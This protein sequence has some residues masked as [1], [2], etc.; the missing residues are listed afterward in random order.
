MYLENDNHRRT[1]KPKITS[2]NEQDQQ[3]FDAMIFSWV[4]LLLRS[5]SI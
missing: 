5:Q 1:F 4:M 3:N 2:L